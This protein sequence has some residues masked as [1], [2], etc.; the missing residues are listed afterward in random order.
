MK[1]DILHVDIYRQKC[2][3]IHDNLQNVVNNNNSFDIKWFPMFHK[4]FPIFDEEQ[5]C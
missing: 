4:L 1:E 3:K 2:E 5:I